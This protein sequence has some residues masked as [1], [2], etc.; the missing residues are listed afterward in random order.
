MITRVRGSD[1]HLVRDMDKCE[2]VMPDTGQNRKYLHQ[3]IFRSNQDLHLIKLIGTR[4]TS[5][6]AT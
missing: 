6:A 1:V 4:L 3:K 2:G 5:G